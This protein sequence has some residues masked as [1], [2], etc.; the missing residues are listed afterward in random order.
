MNFFCYN[1]K[2]LI[3]LIFEL[4]NSTTIIEIKKL[5]I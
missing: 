5:I 1:K 3:I 4:D 2:K